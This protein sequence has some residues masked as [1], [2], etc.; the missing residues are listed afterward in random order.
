MVIQVLLNPKIRLLWM[1]FL[2]NKTN[3][4]PC[5][6]KKEN[7]NIEINIGSNLRSQSG[8]TFPCLDLLIKGNEAYISYIEANKNCNLKAIPNMGTFI[9]D[10]AVTLCEQLNIKNIRLQ[11]KSSINCNNESVSL[12]FLSVMIKGRTWYQSKG[13]NLAN[14]NYNN[15][16]QQIRNTNIDVLSGKINQLSNVKV[17]LWN[18]FV[19]KFKKENKENA[20]FTL[21]DFIKYIWEKDCKIYLELYPLFFNFLPEVRHN[22]LNL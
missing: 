6:I 12:S 8:I 11:D 16:I 4:V 9:H 17:K 18:N 5:L 3:E 7:D 22:Y 2:H 13:Y 14:E 1:L 19:D 10:F 15:V 20:T 21:G